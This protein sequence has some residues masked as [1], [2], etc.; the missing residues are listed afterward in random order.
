MGG[1]STTG[2]MVLP[3]SEADNS[4]TNLISGETSLWLVSSSRKRLFLR[5][6]SRR[7]RKQTLLAPRLSV[8]RQTASKQSLLV[9]RR[10]VPALKARH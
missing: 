10:R 8:A 4:R 1:Q 2:A 6:L 7:G 9:V 5:W 3:A